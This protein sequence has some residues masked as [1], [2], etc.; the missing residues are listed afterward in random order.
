MCAWQMRRNIFVSYVICIVLYIPSFV[1]QNVCVAD[2]EKYICIVRDM[3]DSQSHGIR[4]TINL[5]GSTPVKDVMTQFAGMFGYVEETIDVHYEIQT[6]AELHEV[7][8]S[9]ITPHNQT[10]PY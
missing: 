4:H 2:E 1:V 8:C 7:S 10:R 5:P 6:G 9:T 3:V